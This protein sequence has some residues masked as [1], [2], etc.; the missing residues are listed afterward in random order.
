MMKGAPRDRG[1]LVTH[2][3]A[4]SFTTA[5]VQ[6]PLTWELTRRFRKVMFNVL[7]INVGLDEADMRL[8]LTGESQEISKAKDY[9]RDLGVKLKT[10]STG[11]SRT[12]FPAVPKQLPRGQPTGHQ[13]ERKLWLT[14][15]RDQRPEPFLWTIGRR[16][17]IGYKITHCA[18]GPN[19]A[20]ISLVAWGDAEEIDRTVSYLREQGVCVEYGEAGVSAPFAPL[21]E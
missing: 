3:L 5:H 1:M 20:I 11:R 17:D 2:R 14:I 16:F 21:E 7:S 12:E 8:S 4:L 18:T 15:L 19:M 13:V 6:E 10:L 9:L